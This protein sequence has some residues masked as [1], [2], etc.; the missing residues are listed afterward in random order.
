MHLI[1]RKEEMWTKID[2]SNKES[3][4][5]EVEELGDFSEEVVNTS[6]K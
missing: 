6:E 1:E 5:V 2:L 4:E 3:S